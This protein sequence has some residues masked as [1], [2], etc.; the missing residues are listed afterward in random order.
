[1]HANR[2][3]LQLAPAERRRG[4]GPQLVRREAERRCEHDRHGLSGEMSGARG[5]EHKQEELVR[6]E[7]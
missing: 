1:V 7:R 4:K 3:R 5:D 6:P 2:D